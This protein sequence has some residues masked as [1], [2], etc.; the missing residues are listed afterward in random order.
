MDRF[1]Y[2]ALFALGEDWGMDELLPIVMETGR[3]NLSCM[4]LLDRA[5]TETYGTPEP[6]AVS[7]AVEKGPFIVVT[8][9]DLHDLKLLLEQTEGKGIHIYTHGEM[10]PAH[11][12]PELKKYSH[13]KGNFGTAWQNQQKEFDGLPA[14]VLFTTNCLMPPKPGYADR[15]FTTNMVSFPETPHI[16]AEKDFTPV[17]E[18]ALELGGYGENQDFSGINGGNNCHDRLRP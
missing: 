17:I 9:H 15:V 11:A 10:L 13:L 4:E 6:T 5:N 1:F 7:L 3:Y 16:G 12:Y 8:G 18:K 2:K 14:P